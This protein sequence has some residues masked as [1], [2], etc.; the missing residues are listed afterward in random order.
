MRSG[1]PPPGAAA[2][3][4]PLG[5]WGC[6]VLFGVGLLFKR[7][8]VCVNCF[9]NRSLNGLFIAPSPTQR[10]RLWSRFG[11]PSPAGTLYSWLH[12]PAPR[13]P[14]CLPDFQCCLIC[15]LLQSISPLPLL[16][17]PTTWPGMCS[18]LHA[19]AQC[20]RA[21]EGLAP[22]GACLHRSHAARGSVLPLS[23]DC[24]EASG[25]TAA[26]AAVAASWLC[27]LNQS[28]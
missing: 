14:R 2:P 6:F 20:A 3:R 21:P 26:L 12:S 23:G 11:F 24:L 9:L 25:H 27:P 13:S 4:L 17:G 7:F 5:R 19:C 1:W 18:C 22:G 8:A 10:A 16:G 28:Y 15:S